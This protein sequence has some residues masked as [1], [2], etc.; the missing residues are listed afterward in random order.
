M[1]LVLVLYHLKNPRNVSDIA[2][3][4]NSLGAE[5]ILVRR[6]DAQQALSGVRQADSLSEAVTGYCSRGYRVLVLETYGEPVERVIKG[7]GAGGVVVLVG[8]EDYGIPREEIE[9][10][11]AQGCSVSA[12]RLPMAVPATSYNVASSVAMLLYVL[13]KSGILSR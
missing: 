2:A 4:A 1:D 10:L 3:L 13:K 8:A 9:A 6:P 5:V 11:K 7:L 12:A